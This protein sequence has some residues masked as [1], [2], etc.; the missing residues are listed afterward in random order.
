[1]PYL[2]KPL[3]IFV[4]LNEKQWK[5]IFK[6]NDKNSP[7]PGDEDPGEMLV[8]VKCATPKAWKL[9]TTVVSLLKRISN[10]STQIVFKIAQI[11]Y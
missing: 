8:S 7:Q 1:M 6:H 2:L 10:L 9:N 4:P 3:W 11:L 5:R